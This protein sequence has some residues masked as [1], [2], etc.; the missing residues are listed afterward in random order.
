M[1]RSILD[2]TADEDLRPLE[3]TTPVTTLSG[4]NT[5]PLTQ[6][7]NI[8]IGIKPNPTPGGTLDSP[9][10]PPTGGGTAV[11]GEPLGSPLANPV[12]GPAVATS[13]SGGGN[14][15]APSLPT[16]GASFNS[17]SVVDS[18]NTPIMQQAQVPSVSSARSDSTGNPT[19]DSSGNTLGSS[20]ETP[21][22]FA[23]LAQGKLGQTSAANLSTNP[24]NTLNYGVQGASLDTSA[25]SGSLTNTGAVPQAPIDSLGD[26]DLTPNRTI[27]AMKSTEQGY[28]DNKLTNTLPGN[29]APP[30]EMGDD[31]PGDVSP[32]L[33]RQVTG[34]SGQNRQVDAKGNILDANGQPIGDG[35]GNILRVGTDGTVMAGNKPWGYIQADGQVRQGLR[36]AQGQADPRMGE[37]MDFRGRS[38][39]G[40]SGV[41]RQVDQQ[42]RILSDAG[43]GYQ[44]AEDGS[45]LIVGQDGTITAGGNRWG[46]VDAGGQVRKG[47]PMLGANDGGQP[48]SGQP[49]G[50]AGGQAGGQAGG[51]P[52]AAQAGLISPEMLVENRITNLMRSGNPLL[53][54]ALTR[55][56]QLANER[57]ILNS[58]MAT[59]AGTEAMLSASREIASQ[60]ANT[61]KDAALT[62]YQAKVQMIMQ[63]KSLSAQQQ[64]NALQRAF[65]QRENALAR[66]ADI[67]ARAADRNFQRDENATQRQFQGDMTREG[68]RLDSE[69]DTLNYQR[70]IANF[71]RQIAASRD[72]NDRNFFRTMQVNYNQSILTLQTDPNMTPETRAAQINALNSIYAGM[73]YNGQFLNMVRPA[74]ET[75]SASSDTGSGASTGASSGT[76]SR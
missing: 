22:G 12:V 70:N 60:D 31:A 74:S 47:S 71:D 28:Q 13:I 20:Y 35:Q 30:R 66:A 69:R 9:P 63:D 23:R 7:P 18:V 44:L 14:A 75:P 53:E 45:Q 41:A 73:T 61:L 6:D 5:K 33:N 38:I 32:F 51:T 27:E 4:N 65:Q 34:V 40:L 46:Y 25:E 26:T 57:G 49:G 15:A 24:N 37:G 42:G 59:Q 39:I 43:G 52:I 54:Q 17:G 50:G 72:D 21:E 76:N 10:N 11:L 29:N 68:W 8:G 56:K 64:E 3:A 19:R 2:M 67:E 48:G 58:T 55:A 62:E 16:S 36:P 1:P